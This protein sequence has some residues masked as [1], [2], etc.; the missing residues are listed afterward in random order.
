M[1]LCEEIRKNREELKKK[2]E[3]DF[4]E[5]LNKEIDESFSWWKNTGRDLV[6]V[7]LESSEDPYL[8]VTKSSIPFWPVKLSVP[9]M[10]REEI[11]QLRHDLD[12]HYNNIS[13]LIAE[14][15]IVVVESVFDW[16]I[17]LEEEEI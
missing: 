10:K 7:L 5:S 9:V 15:G 11:D 4:E 17:C 13:E 8:I 12:K 6:K 1:R 3:L 14:D 16:Y 2:E